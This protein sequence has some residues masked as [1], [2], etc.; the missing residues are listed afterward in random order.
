MSKIGRN[1]NTERLERFNKIWESVNE[2]DVPVI[3]EGKRD[4]LAVRQL[5]YSGE[6]VQLND[7]KS[8]LHTV[9]NL[10]KVLGIGSKFVIL[11]DWDRTG[12]KL[13]KA[14]EKYGVSCDLSPN[15]QVWRDLMSLCSKD[16]TCIEELPTFVSML[17]Q[18]I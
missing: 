16:I 12:I 13:A 6:L 15:L 7:G 3:V 4:I 10:A 5:G 14:L 8:I 9:E 2:F 1:S 17:K 11:M 18:R